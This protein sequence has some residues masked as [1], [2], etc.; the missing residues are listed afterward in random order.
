MSGFSS[1]LTFC[2]KRHLQTG[3]S[4]GGET[5]VFAAKTP[6]LYCQRDLAKKRKG[7][8]F[9]AIPKCPRGSLEIHRSAD[10]HF[11]CT[12][13]GYPYSHFNSVL[14]PAVMAQWLSVIAE[15]T[16]GTLV[17]LSALAAVF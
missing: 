2:E 7:V 3:A 12:V 13:V 15:L 16:T 6:F 11:R 5:Y 10:A 4:C 1:K 17:R 9:T 8:G 14:G